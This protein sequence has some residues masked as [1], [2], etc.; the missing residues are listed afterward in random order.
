MCLSLYFS[1]IIVVVAIELLAACQALDF[2]K[3]KH[4][5]STVP[6]EKVYKVVR[7]EVTYVGLVLL[8]YNLH[9]TYVV[10]KHGL[11][12]TTYRYLDKDRYM[13]S[14]MLA[15]TRML[16]AGKVNKEL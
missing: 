6:L 12:T 1:F 16:Q 9:N 15:V 11:C 7:S 8:L 2:H 4:H 14:D 5:N 10:T 13:A 3:E